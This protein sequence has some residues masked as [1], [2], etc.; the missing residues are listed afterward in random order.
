VHALV[1]LAQATAARKE[2]STIGRRRAGNAALAHHRGDRCGGVLGRCST[3]TGR[4]GEAVTSEQV[5][6]ILL[7]A[8][9]GA[10]LVP[11]PRLDARLRSLE[12]DDPSLKV[13]AAARHSLGPRVRE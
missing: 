1:L 8:I 12:Q 13:R 7:Q 10:A 4:A 5:E 3:A 6:G 9:A 2:R 11:D